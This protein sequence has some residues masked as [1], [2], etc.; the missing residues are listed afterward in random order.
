MP[1]NGLRY[2]P[3]PKSAHGR[4]KDY[5]VLVGRRA[6]AMTVVAKGTFP[7]SAELQ[8]LAFPTT[9][10]EFV[11]FRVLTVHTERPMAAV[12][13]L[14]IL[15]DLNAAPLQEVTGWLGDLKADVKAGVVQVDRNAAG[16]PLMVNGQ[17]FAKGLGVKAPTELVY[18]LDGAW[19]RLSGH[20]GVDGS[21]DGEGAT[22][23]V[24]ADGQRIFESPVMNARN[25]K[26]LLDLNVKGVR[27]LRLQFQDGGKGTLGDWLDMRLVRKGSEAK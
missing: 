7:D 8:T 25:I 5:E 18:Q 26:Q 11:T 9:W 12:A 20:V 22:F 1:V 13:E 21:S 2:L 24:V 23:R 4:I 19:D 27:E 10:G 17:A 6:G 16:R 14:D 3:R 15:Q